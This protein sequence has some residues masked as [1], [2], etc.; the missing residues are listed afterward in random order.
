MCKMIQMN[1]ETYQPIMRFL[2]QLDLVPLEKHFDLNHYIHM[3]RQFI[4]ENWLAGEITTPEIET[5][6]V[7]SIYKPIK[8]IK[9]QGDV[10]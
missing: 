2:V 10:T 5:L 4:I 8:A 9:D 6:L 3:T 1:G 7:G